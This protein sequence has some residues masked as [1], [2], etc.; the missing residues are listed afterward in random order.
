MANK[1]TSS[2]NNLAVTQHFEEIQ[3]IA[4]IGLWEWDIKTNAVSWSVELYRIFGVT[5]G[6]EL[7]YDIFM[8]CVHPDD[9][10]MIDLKIKQT[11]LEDTHYMVDH[12]IILKDGS[13]RYIHGQGDCVFDENGQPERLLGT[14]QDVT[15]SRRTQLELQRLFSSSQDLI[16]TTGLDGHFKRLNPAFEHLLGF[17]VDEFQRKPFMD[18]VHPEDQKATSNALF[19]LSKNGYLVNFENR[20]LH[21]DGSCKWLSW[22]VTIDSEYGLTYATARDITETKKFQ[23]SLEENEKLLQKA[24]EKY[25]TLFEFSGDAYTLVDETGFTDCNKTALTLFGFDKKE[26]MLAKHPADLSPEKQPDGSDSLTKANAQIATALLNGS[27]R[28]EWMHCKKDGTVFPAEILLNTYELSGNIVVQAVVR[29]ISERKCAEQ[30]RQNSY[31]L[32]RIL[33]TIILKSFEDKPIKPLLQEILGTILSAPIL[34]IKPQGAIFL[35]EENSG[36]L[37][38]EAQQ[39]LPAPIKKQCAVVPF[40]KCLCGRAAE[41]QKIQ[42]A[43]CIDERHEIRFEGMKGHGHYNIPILLKNRVL[44]V[45]MIY[46]EEGYKKNVQDIEFFESIAHTLAGIIQRKRFESE[47]KKTKETVEQTNQELDITNQF[48]EKALEET[49]ILALEADDANKAKSE[50]LANMSHEIRTPMNGVMGMASLLLDTALNAEQLDYA[51]SI[52]RS[53]DALLSV[54]ND[55]LDFSKIEAGKLLIEPIP[56]DLRVAVEEVANILL[57]KADAQKI[58][59]IVRY[60]PDLPEQVVGDPGRIRQVITNLSN[61]AIKFTHHG[62][63]FINVET[64]QKSKRNVKFRISVEDTGIGIEKEKLDTIFDKFTQA[65]SSTTRKYGGTGLGLSISKQLIEL[66]GGNIS[67]HSEPGKGST[68]AF[69]LKLPIA[70]GEKSS[71]GLNTKLDD[72]KV[73]IVDDN[74]INRKILTEFT[75]KWGMKSKAVSTGKRA[76]AELLSASKAGH[77]Y[78][79]VLLDNLMPGETGEALGKRIHE[80]AD[81]KSSKLIMLTSSGGKGDARRL[82]KLGFD[83]YLPKPIRISHLHKILKAI[84]HL[85]PGERGKRFIT[86]YTIMEAEKHAARTLQQT[87]KQ[88]NIRILLAED[89]LI[90]QK[91]AVKMLKKFGFEIV[92]IAE[93]GRKVIELL[94]KNSYSLIFMDC[95]M[96]ELDG[97][98]T[99]KTIRKRENRK[100]RIPIIA[101]TANAMKG[102]EEKCTASG[103]DDFIS[104]PVKAELIQSKLR[105]WLNLEEKSGKSVPHYS[106]GKKET[107]HIIDENKEPETTKQ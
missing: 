26:D 62:Y 11:L 70:K 97:Y 61:N 24:E 13:I 15:E 105:K 99:T 71:I 79:L 91:V 14:A 4:K 98:E 73:L 1:S 55:I 58:E 29:D 49:K 47:I 18:F 100:Q 56:F 43:S 67:A 2:Q 51:K 31:H 17:S 77:P 23:C 37:S 87:K 107:V 81:I 93:N 42:H 106:L 19:N 41:T 8:Q 95:Q 45:L 38:M 78:D 76:Y 69:T 3:R 21:K 25:R 35:V 68:F 40:G 7:N 48:L 101:M 22:K 85:S 34:K 6:T 65:D 28:F 30:L 82:Q 5:P 104:K 103:M 36:I 59:L 10:N 16:C 12:R 83:G 80:N 66:M 32:Q 92:D 20:F 90:N 94:K 52:E 63:V 33:N 54:I 64:I 89:N 46:L 44:G 75:K 57:P 39:N 74:A 96:P 86:Q 88:S 50:F 53:A 60:A 9:R 72:G 84:Q 102:D 27:H